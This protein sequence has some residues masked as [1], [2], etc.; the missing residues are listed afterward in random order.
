[1]NVMEVCA[2]RRFKKE[3]QHPGP[4]FNDIIN[5]NNLFIYIGP[6]FNDIINTNNL[7]IYMRSQIYVQMCITIVEK[8]RC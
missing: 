4:N 2:S 7:L 5:T 1:M 8:C 6:N 3:D